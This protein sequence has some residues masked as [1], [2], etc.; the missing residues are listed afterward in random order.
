MIDFYHADTIQNDGANAKE[1]FNLLLI[2]DI[3][4][5]NLRR[6]YRDTL[7]PLPLLLLRNST[8]PIQLVASRHDM[9]RHAI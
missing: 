9:T 7:Y 6:I 5:L 1:R 8:S 3:L 4:L 2:V